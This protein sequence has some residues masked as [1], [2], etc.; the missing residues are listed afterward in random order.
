MLLKM[1]SWI[2][3]SA[4]LSGLT[5]RL[6]RPSSATLG[7]CRSSGSGTVRGSSRGIGGRLLPIWLPEKSLILLCH[8]PVRCCLT[9]SV[10]L[11]TANVF[12]ELCSVVRNGRLFTALVF[13]HA[14]H[15]QKAKNLCRFRPCDQ[16]LYR[17]WIIETFRLS[18][19]FCCWLLKLGATGAEYT[20]SYMQPYHD[21]QL[22]FFSRFECV[23][24]C[25]Y[26]IPTNLPE[27]KSGINFLKKRDFWSKSGTFLQI[28]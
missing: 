15:L 12:L 4:V 28:W 18:S 17:N 26:H 9:I 19:K 24:L 21:I 22:H 3:K 27:A 11:L 16:I 25:I 14:L 2:N 10:A 5:M 7:S 20:M 6:F 13:S 8:T 1:S 23:L